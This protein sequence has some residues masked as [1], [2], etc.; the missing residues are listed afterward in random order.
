MSFFNI[1]PRRNYA[2]HAANVMCTSLL[3]LPVPCPDLIPPGL[4]M[5]M[6]IVNLF[7]EEAFAG[8]SAYS[9]LI[10]DREQRRLLARRGDI[11]IM[12]QSVQHR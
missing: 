4:D 12:S 6:V 9:R 8:N 1:S 2:K 11:C 10:T 3:H 5:I 7:A